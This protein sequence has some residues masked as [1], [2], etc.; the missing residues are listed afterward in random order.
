M[1]LSTSLSR[2]AAAGC[3]AAAALS[4]QAATFA[5]ISGGAGDCSVATSTIHWSWDGSTFTVT[6]DGIGYVAEVYFDL[7]AG[8][9]A[10]FSGGTGTVLFSPG[11]SPAALPGGTSVGFS[12]DAAF[13][14]DPGKGKPVNGIDMGESA[15]FLI[16]GALL[17]SFKD[18]NLAAG[19]HV[20]S[21]A[22]SSVS[23]LTVPVTAVPEPQSY[24]LMLAGLGVMGWLARRRRI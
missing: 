13:D 1:T 21:L 8:M 10:S 22:T 11:A 17:D 5:C 2:L 15:S 23:L 19:L 14:S 20:R 4:S 6:N 16:T 3:L 12:S 24:A 9:T 7:S 18:G